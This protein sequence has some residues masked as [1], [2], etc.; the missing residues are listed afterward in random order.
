MLN[1][2]CRYAD[3]CYTECHYAERRNF[4]SLYTC[5]AECSY[6]KCGGTYSKTILESFHNKLACIQLQ[7][8]NMHFAGRA[9]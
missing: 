5:Y 9:A 6:A 2:E 3:Y 7:Y 1:A 4:Q 8:G